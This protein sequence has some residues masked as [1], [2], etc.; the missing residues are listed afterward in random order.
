MTN[1]IRFKIAITIL[2][3]IAAFINY[4]VAS[5]GAFPVDTFVH[6]D[7][8]FRIVKGQ[9]PIADYWIVHGLVVDYIQSIFF[10][11]F[12]A[13]WFSYILHS[14][15][16][17]SV[18]C[19]FSLIIF[20]KYLKIEFKLSI[21]FSVLICILAYPI[22]GSPFLDLHS[23]YFS[24][25]STYFIII[26]I[27]TN[28]K[29]FWFIS[30]FL[31][32]AAFFSKQVPAFYVILTTTIFCIYYSI[33]KKDLKILI[34][35]SCG[36]LLFGIILLIFIFFQGIEI[37]DLI[38]QLFLYPQSIGSSRYLN[39]GLNF[40][41]LFLNFK[42]IHLFLIFILISNIILIRKKNYLKSKKFNIAIVFVLFSISCIFHQIYTKNQIFIF[43]LIPLLACL[44][45][46]YLEDLKKINKKYFKFT[47]IL[48]CLFFSLKYIERFLI[49]RK[50]HELNNTRL[51]N[52]IKINSF[53]EKLKGLNWITPHFENPQDEIDVL[54]KLKNL[55]V[56]DK[57]NKMLLTEYNF[58][59]LLLN[60]NLNGPS[61]TYDN[62]SYPNKNSKYYANYRYFLK[63]R[64]NQNKI[65][66]IYILEPKKINQNRLDHLIFNYIK[67]DC[68]SVNFIDNFITKLEIKE[69]NDLN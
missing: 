21:L 29:K 39:Y 59:S 16:F 19:I 1:N 52:R 33:L 48:L 18:I 28:K 17:N 64:L 45:I 11:T 62:I 47:I 68:F 53:D 38:L 4:Y 24:L 3:F 63:E 58:F 50:F 65:K 2:I 37:K 44:S 36:G 30:S 51:E 41:N 14:S 31:L 46:Y 49:E 26:A 61:R 5:R 69:C 20:Y 56:N 43:F 35:Y 25:F 9:K 54:N 32:G 27:L 7:N 23:I 55:L 57:D 34:F 60:E 8:G 6:F 42:F 40:E 13:S 10:F 15:I 12:G 67:A 22:S 66:S